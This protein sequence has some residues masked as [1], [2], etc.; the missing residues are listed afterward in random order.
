M[1]GLRPDYKTISEFRR[2]NKRA[3]A[4]VLKQCARLCIKLGLIAGNTLFVDGSKMRANAGINHTWTKDRCDK[5]LKK[6]DKRIESILMECEKV[7][8]QEEDQASFVKMREELENKKVLKSKVE[9]IL[10]ELK[11]GEKKSIN[12]TDKECVK[13]KGRQGIHAGYNAQSV[14]DEKH[15]LIVQTDVVSDSNDLHQFA[16]QVDQANKTLGKKCSVACADS[17]YSDTDELKKVADQEIKVIVPSSKQAS[18]KGL[19]SFDK[20]NFQFDSE[21]DCYI[22]PEG[23]V[24]KYSYTNKAKKRREYQITSSQLCKKCHHFGVC[25]ISKRGRKISRLLNEDIRRQFESEYEQPESQEVYKL[26]QQKVELPFGHIKRNLNVDAF[27][28]RGREGAKA[29]MSILASCFNMARMITVLG[30]PLL[31]E[32]LTA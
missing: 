19:S 20:E 3:I 10:K 18:K 14:V 8:K 15:G 12:T 24:L 4:K 2:K 23:N 17:G 32:K 11:E 30:V 7:D 13:V 21:K 22:C 16:E 5:A 28:L 31:M 6:V 27:L 1:G 25:T 9:T 29:E 26:R